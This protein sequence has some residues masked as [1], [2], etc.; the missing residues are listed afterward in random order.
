MRWPFELEFALTDFLAD[1]LEAVEVFRG[2]LE[3]PGEFRT[4]S[5]PCAVIS[6][7]TRKER[8]VP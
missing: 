4:S 1:E 2:H 6:I 7:W 8:N 3:V 5:D